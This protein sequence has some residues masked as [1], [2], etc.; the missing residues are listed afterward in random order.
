MRAIGFDSYGDPDVMRLRD[1]PV[2]E[3]QEG[4]V[5]PKRRKQRLFLA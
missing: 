4:E 3:P 5:V 2:P 1:L